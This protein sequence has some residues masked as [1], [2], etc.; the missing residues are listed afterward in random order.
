MP[1]YYAKFQL[2]DR[3]NALYPKDDIFLLK[4]DGLYIYIIEEFKNEINCNKRELNRVFILFLPF[5][6]V[7]IVLLCRTQ[8]LY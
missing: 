3:L 2:I 1:S 8:K 5:M 6:L 4:I 7:C